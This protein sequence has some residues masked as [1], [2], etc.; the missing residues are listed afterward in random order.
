MIMVLLFSSPLEDTSNI[1]MLP[2]SDGAA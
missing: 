2:S 1:K